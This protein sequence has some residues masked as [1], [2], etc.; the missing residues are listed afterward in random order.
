LAEDPSQRQQ[1][2]HALREDGVYVD[3]GENDDRIVRKLVNDPKALG[4]MGFNFYQANQHRLKAATIDAVSPSFDSIK[5]GEYRLSRPLYLYVK[6]FHAPYIKNLLAFVEMVMS[7]QLSGPQGL[8]L[9]YGLVPL[10]R[11]VGKSGACQKLHGG[12]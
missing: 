4:V 5:S 11:A 1:L 2:C 9:D 8:L 3:D 10:P 12:C 7:P 6:P